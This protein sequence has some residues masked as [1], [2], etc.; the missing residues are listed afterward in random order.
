MVPNL[1]PVLRASQRSEQPLP[2]GDAGRRVGNPCFL[3]QALDLGSDQPP[4]G[5]C[6]HKAD[7]FK[8]L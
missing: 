7:G 3:Q 1:V 2:F 8:M 5:I 6:K 4:L